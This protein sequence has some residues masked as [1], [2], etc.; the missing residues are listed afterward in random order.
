[1]GMTPPNGSSMLDNGA[2]NKQLGEDYKQ[3]L[4]HVRSQ[5][6]DEL[7]GRL[8]A[9]ASGSPLFAPVLQMKVIGDRFTWGDDRLL[10]FL[11]LSL[12]Q[13]DPKK[14]T[15]LFGDSIRAQNL[16]I[17]S[18]FDNAARDLEY[19]NDGAEFALEKMKN[20]PRATPKLAGITTDIEKLNACCREIGNQ[21]KET[22]CGAAKQ[23]LDELAPEA[24]ATRRPINKN[25][26]NAAQ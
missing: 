18:E 5:L 15:E 20:V 21:M 19:M 3:W 9:A 12:R 23:F 22:L 8:L 7:K 4:T 13:S 6:N 24:P 17:G 26:P 14:F 25:T 10:S 11:L 2:Q 16:Q 1:M